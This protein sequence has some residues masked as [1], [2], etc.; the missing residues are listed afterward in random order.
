MARRKEIRRRRLEKARRTGALF[1][2]GC[3]FDAECPLYEVIDNLSDPGLVGHRTELFAGTVFWTSIATHTLPGTGTNCCFDAECPLYEVKLRQSFRI[4]RAGVGH[5]ELNY[6]SI[7]F[8][9]S[10]ETHTVPGIG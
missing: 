3:C 5:T 4:R 7:P 2:C 1:E 10:I 8:W 6:F 9:T